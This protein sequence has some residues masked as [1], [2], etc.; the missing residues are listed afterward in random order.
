MFLTAAIDSLTKC[1]SWSKGKVTQKVWPS[2]I[3][4]NGEPL[5]YFYMM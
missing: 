1:N 5:S 2:N 3:I 4:V